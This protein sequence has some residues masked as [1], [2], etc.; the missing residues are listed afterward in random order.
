MFFPFAS[1]L[2]RKEKQGNSKLPWPGICGERISFAG[3]FPWAVLSM[4]RTVHVLF[5]EGILRSGRGLGVATNS[6]EA[7]LD[8]VFKDAG[9]RDAGEE[10]SFKP[11][12]FL[13]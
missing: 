1:L 2:T 5:E 12:S 10:I 7:M 3:P 4:M 9:M 8:V 6:A 11:K 13:A